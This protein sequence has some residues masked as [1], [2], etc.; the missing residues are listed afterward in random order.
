[1]MSELQEL[2][3]DLILDHGRNPRHFGALPEADQMAE[4]FNPLCGD[5]LKIYL[6]IDATRQ[7]VSSIQFSGEGCAISMA[8]ASMMAET[9]KGKTLLEVG[10]ICQL[11]SQ[12]VTVGTSNLDVADKLGKLAVL[13]G[14]RAFPSRVKCATLAWHTLQ[15]ALKQP[16]HTAT[17]E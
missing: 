13:A 14:V 6:S 11:F 4:G 8:S 17:T 7:T 5:K 1:M 9:L 3:H 16:G 12:Q 2:Y 10:E 15:M